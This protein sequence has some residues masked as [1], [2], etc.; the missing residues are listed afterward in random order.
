M[1]KR[2]WKRKCKE[3]KSNKYKAVKKKHFIVTCTKKANWIDK[4]ETLRFM[5][6]LIVYQWPQHQ[7]CVRP[8]T[9]PIRLK[10]HMETRKGLFKG[11]WSHDRGGLNAHIWLKALYKAYFEQDGQWFSDLACIILDGGL[12]SLFKWRS[13]I[14]LTYSVSRS[15]LLCKAVK[16]E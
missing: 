4:V 11:S 15:N 8:S 5:G 10:F 3:E 7:P 12:P 16:W 14:D 13:Y 1:W 9:G 2:K 6:D